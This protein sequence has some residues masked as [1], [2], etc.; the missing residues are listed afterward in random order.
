[1]KKDIILFFLIVLCA[2]LAICALLLVW[3]RFSPGFLME[4][5]SGAT[6]INMTLPSGDNIVLLAQEG[7]NTQ[8]LPHGTAFVQR[9]V[10]A[11]TGTA[12]NFE[13]ADFTESLYGID[14]V[15]AVGGSFTMGCAPEREDECRDNEK[16]AHNVTLSDFYIGKYEVTQAQWKAVM[17]KDNNP[18]EFIGDDLPVTNVNWYEAQVFVIKLNEK[19]GK[20]YRLPTDAEWEYAARGGNQSRGYK[21]SGSDDVNDVA[22]YAKNSGDTTHTVGTKTAN[23]LGI[24]DM[25]GNVWEWVFDL[26]MVS[27]NYYTDEARTNPQQPEGNFPLIRGGGWNLHEA[28]AACPSCSSRVL[29]H[30]TNFPT[31]KSNRLGFRLAHD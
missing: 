3:D 29:F 18:S 17:G 6:R 14:M 31:W 24:F 15:Y 11:A 25:S 8:I 20:N 19:T 16:P 7:D 10:P 13:K 4:S 12:H 2:T 28:T 22:W 23:E 30:V 9:I 21:Y 26:V 27:R 1:M 5:R